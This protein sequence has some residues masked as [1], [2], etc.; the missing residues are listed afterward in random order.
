MRRQE[1]EMAL[2]NVQKE[3]QGTKQQKPEKY[4]LREDH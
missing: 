1:G 2:N 3:T 4:A